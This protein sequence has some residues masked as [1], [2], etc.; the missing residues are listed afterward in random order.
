MIAC[1]LE[2]MARKG[3]QDHQALSNISFVLHHGDSLGIV[4]LN[5]SGKSTLLEIIVG[6]L[7]ASS[8]NVQ[9]NGRVAALLQLGSGFDSQ[10][11]GRENILINGVVLGLAKKEIEERYDEIVAFADIGKFI[12]YPMHTYSTGMALRLAFSLQVHIR[13]DILVVDE[14]LAVGDAKFRAKAEQKIEELLAGGTTLL[15]V[16]HNLDTVKSFCNRAMLLESGRMTQIG[17]PEQVIERYLYLVQ[18]DVLVQKGEDAVG[19]API[20]NGFGYDGA[21]VLRANIDGVADHKI[22]RYDQ[23]FHVNLDILLEKEIDSP[24][25]IFDIVNSNGMQVTGKRI[26]LSK[27]KG[28]AIKVAIQM[29]AT[30]QQG[31]YRIRTRVVNAP[32]LSQTTLLSRQEGFLSFELIDDS[33]EHFTGLFPLPMEVTQ[34]SSSSVE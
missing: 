1:W 16:G 22:L 20:D 17:D 24:Y 28:V 3:F 21:K 10:L 30:L 8:G 29:R 31:L 6:V 25:L 23:T 13:P 19:F 5:G 15:F 34:H 11:T 27:D 12:D 18:H 32:S 7:E 26:A 9:V 2:R 4:G 33:R 14:A